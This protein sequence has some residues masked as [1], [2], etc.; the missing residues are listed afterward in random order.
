MAASKI[1]QVENYYT[2][3]RQITDLVQDMNQS[4]AGPDA[5]QPLNLNSATLKQMGESLEALLRTLIPSMG[6]IFRDAKQ[7]IEQTL[8]TDI[9]PRFVKHQL[10]L[11]AENGLSMKGLRTQGWVIA[12]V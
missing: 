12:F 2:L 7:F 10:T 6:T 8:I 3:L 9:Y 1:D 5:P 11:S 4:F